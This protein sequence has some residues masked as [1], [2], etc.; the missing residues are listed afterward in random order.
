MPVSSDDFIDLARRLHESADTEIDL[1]AAISR[2]YY[3]AYHRASFIENHLGPT[4][5]RPRGVHDQFIQKLVE[6]THPTA[7]DDGKRLLRRLGYK[8]IAQ[9]NLRAQA[10]YH[11]AETVNEDDTSMAINRF[12]A[13]E[14]DIEEV[15]QHFGL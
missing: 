6:A 3:G 14:Q 9:K 8:L 7:G 10:D 4:A 1:R 11:L 5:E 2:A 15:E 13:I 12:S